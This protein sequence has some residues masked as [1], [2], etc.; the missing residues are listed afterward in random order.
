MP[1]FGGRSYLRID[2]YA[3]PQMRREHGLNAA[4][5]LTL[6]GLAERA[7][8]RTDSGGSRYFT[9]TKDELQE[10]TGQSPNTITAAMDRLAA[11]GCVTV[12]ES[13][14]RNGQGR[15]RIDVWDEL[16]VPS[17]ARSDHGDRRHNADRQFSA[18]PPREVRHDKRTESPPVPHEIAQSAGYDQG[19]S[20]IDRYAVRGDE[21]SES[22]APHDHEEWVAFDPDEPPPWQTSED[23]SVA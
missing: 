20:M 23:W 5:T 1:K 8:E 14:T 7:D 22:R 11:K 4:D 6:R 15:I 21:V 2:K 13:F 17:Q 16:V 19:K 3:M 18:Y 10:W 9:G 12:I